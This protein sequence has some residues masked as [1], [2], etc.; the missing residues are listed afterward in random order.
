MVTGFRQLEAVPSSSAR[1]CPS[2]GVPLHWKLRRELRIQGRS[3]KASCEE[4]DP[5]GKPRP[6]ECENEDGEQTMGAASQLRKEGRS[7]GQSICPLKHHIVA[8]CDGFG[9]KGDQPK[10]QLLR[11]EFGLRAPEAVV[12]RDSDQRRT[13]SERSDFGMR[14]PRAVIV[15]KR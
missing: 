4:E 7:R 8:E 9:G 10:N 15:E 3:R 11:T 12:A 14:S 1:A 13:K 6:V 5:E 2:R